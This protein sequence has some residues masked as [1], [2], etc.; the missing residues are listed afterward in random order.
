MYKIVFLL[1][2]AVIAAPA[3]AQSG[4]LTFDPAQLCGWQEKNNGMNRDECLKLEDEAKAALAELESK[5]EQ[6]RK[7]ECQAEAKNY[8]GDSGFASYT[9]FAECLK[10]GPGSL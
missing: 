6:A 3:L 5:A 1:V 10:N 4:A 2:A 7:D 8:S 9:V